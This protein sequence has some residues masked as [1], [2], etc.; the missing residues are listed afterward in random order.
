[1]TPRNSVFQAQQTGRLH[2]GT[3]R[4]WEPMWDLH[5]FKPDTHPSTEKGYTQSP[6]H[7]PEAICKLIPPGNG[8]I[9]FLQGHITEYIQPHS[10]A[11]P[12]PRSTRP[13]P[14]RLYAAFFVLFY[15]V[16][17]FLLLGCFAFWLL[18]MFCC[19]VLF[20]FLKREFITVLSNLLGPEINVRSLNYLQWANYF[21]K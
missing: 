4:D 2:T 21:G 1:M 9:S 17:A 10:R 20:C 16:L 5:R 3:H 6:T 14:S 8:K 7:D 12:I 19:F 15:Y 18:L 13:A 11:G